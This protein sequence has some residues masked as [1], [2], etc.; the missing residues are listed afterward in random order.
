MSLTRRA[1]Q[2]YNVES[3]AHKV[4]SQPKPKAAPLHK[5]NIAD[6]ENALKLEPNLLEKL[7][8]KDQNLHERLKHVFVSAE[9]KMEDQIPERNLPSERSF[10]EDFEF[11]YKD[12][13]TAPPG[14]IR[15]QTFLQFL[16]DH[17]RDPI[18]FDVNHLHQQNG[19]SIET[20]NHI[21]KYYKLLA[22]QINDPKLR[23][24]PQLTD[25]SPQPMIEG[26]RK[27]NRQ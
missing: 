7:N 24:R 17:H 8:R 15:M 4:I 9:H 1:A 26:K 23:M 14:K 10:V 21:L 25:T 27:D 6:L 16:Q 11:G 2:R 18:Q 3:R 5:S 19:V 12:D 13:E 22:V 20:A